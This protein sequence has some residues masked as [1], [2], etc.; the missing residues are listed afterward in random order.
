MIHESH[1]EKVVIIVI[2]YEVTHQSLSLEYLVWFLRV[3]LIVQALV[4]WK[5]FKTQGTN[6]WIYSMAIE[7]KVFF[8][9]TVYS[10]EWVSVSVNQEQRIE[11]QSDGHHFEEYRRKYKTAQTSFEWMKFW[12]K[13]YN[14]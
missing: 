7:D 8:R 1:I 4:H 14:R 5:C 2:I 10:V 6:L 3:N 13:M 11:T 9:E 12:L